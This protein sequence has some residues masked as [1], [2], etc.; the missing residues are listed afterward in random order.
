MTIRVSL[1]AMA[2]AATLAGTGG[3]SAETTLTIATVNNPDMV[4]MQKYS[5]EF[6]K[7]TGIKLNWLVL[8]ENVLRQRVTTDISTKGGQFDIITIGM[9][10]APMWGKNGWLN[11]FDNLPADYD[12]NDVLPSVRQGLSYDGKLYALPFYAESTLT[13]YRTDLFKKAGLTMPDQPTWTQIADFAAKLDDKTNGVYG[14][15]IRGQPGWG[16]NLAL[17]NLMGNVYGGQIF[18]MDWTSGF[19]SDAFKKAVKLYVDLGNKYGPPGMVGNGFNE[20]LALMSSGKCAM[21]IDASVAGG[22]LYD[23]KRSKIA[24]S[25]GVAQAPVETWNM[26]KGWLWSWALGIPSSSQ[27]VDEAKK[28]VEWA[29]SKN[30]IKMIGEKEGW[31]TAPPGTRKSTYANAAYMA[32]APFAP[33]TLSSIEFEDPVHTTQHDKPYLGVNFAAVPEYQGI[34]TFTAQ[35]VAAALTGK[36]SVDDALAAAAAN[37]DKVMKKAGYIK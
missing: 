32:A 9:L 12:V 17:V 36:A 1:A 34:G 33:A 10:E 8:E 19:N 20:N 25:V 30:Y 7:D 29:T 37:S 21:W 14:L 23:P 11:P 5:S 35:Q 22:V 24:D 31:V 15:C 28:F 2:I 26:G 3:A 4:V 16:E 13:F 18:N 27:H 6:E